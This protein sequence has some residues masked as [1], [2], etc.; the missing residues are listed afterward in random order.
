LYFAFGHVLSFYSEYH[1]YEQ[2][3]IKHHIAWFLAYPMKVI[4]ETCR[5][6]TVWYLCVYYYN[7]QN[8]FHYCGWK[9]TGTN[10]IDTTKH[11]SILCRHHSPIKLRGFRCYMSTISQPYL[12][13]ISIDIH[14]LPWDRH[15]NIAGL[16]YR[17]IIYIYMIT[18]AFTL[19][20]LNT[21]YLF[22]WSRHVT[23]KPP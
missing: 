8:G 11:T 15:I 16:I 19:F 4:P 21:A 5:V 1:Y 22:K 12:Q 20:L 17:N 23:T 7:N 2:N 18:E 10:F 6:H 14:I 3:L 9:T 13:H